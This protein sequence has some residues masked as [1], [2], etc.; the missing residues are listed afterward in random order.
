MDLRC[1]EGRLTGR[2]TC[3]IPVPILQPS[4]SGTN[5]RLLSVLLLLGSISLISVG[6][7]AGRFNVPKITNGTSVSIGRWNRFAK[8]M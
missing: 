6:A 5:F 2:L 3:L 4:C 7:V 8:R 1:G